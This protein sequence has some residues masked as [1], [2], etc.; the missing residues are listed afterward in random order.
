MINYITHSISLIPNP[1][2]FQGTFRTFRDLLVAR[3]IKLLRRLGAQ[4][5][6]GGTSHLRWKGGENGV[7]MV[8]TGYK[9]HWFCR[10]YW[11]FS[12]IWM[13]FEGFEQLLSNHGELR[14]WRWGDSNLHWLVV[15]PPTR[16]LVFSLIIMQFSDKAKHVFFLVMEVAID[17]T[18]FHTSEIPKIAGYLMTK[19]HLFAPFTSLFP[20]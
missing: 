17:R 14:K 11:F 4:T 12:R 5:M 9:H 3:H 1:H 7:K 15:E 19:V 13:I 16:I 8:W 2:S 6:G 20:S 18:Q 10:I